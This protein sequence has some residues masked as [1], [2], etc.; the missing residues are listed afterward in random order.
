MRMSLFQDRYGTE[1]KVV[2]DIYR[3]EP[4]IG[5]FHFAGSQL[6][7]RHIGQSQVTDHRHSL[8]LQSKEFTTIRFSPKKFTRY[9][10][11]KPEPP[12]LLD[13][14][15]YFSEDTMDLS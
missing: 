9:K 4:A 3:D 8:S 11:L 6:S 2:I 13:I 12:A 15:P 7:G 10:Q 1:P 5:A 14:E